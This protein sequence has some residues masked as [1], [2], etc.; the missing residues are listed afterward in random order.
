M[1]SY[2]EMHETGLGS[3]RAALTWCNV[4]DS[5]GISLFATKNKVKREE[6][7][8]TLLPQVEETHSSDPKQRNVSSRRCQWFLHG[9]AGYTN[10]IQTQKYQALRPKTVEGWWDPK[11]LIFAALSSVCWIPW[12]QSEQFR[13]LIRGGRKFRNPACRRVAAN[14]LMRLQKMWWHPKYWLCKLRIP[15]LIFSWT[16]TTQNHWVSANRSHKQEATHL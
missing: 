12:T 15:F 8:M 9:E 6:R 5:V 1:K 11:L 10:C 2:Y 7:R 3:T 13:N 4:Q 14:M 16:Q